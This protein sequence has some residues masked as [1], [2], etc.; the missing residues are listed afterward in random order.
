MKKTLIFL[1]VSNI[2]NGYAQKSEININN[3]DIIKGFSDKVCLCLDSVDTVNKQKTELNK[4]IGDCIDKQVVVYQLSKKLANSVKKGEEIKETNI[5]ININPD[6]KDYK[7]SYYE[8]EEYLF[9]NCERMKVLVAAS[10]FHTDKSLS[11]NALALEFYYAGI[12]E[13]E[14]ENWSTAIENYKMAVQ[15]DPEFAFAWDN[16]GI[17]Y[18]RIKDYDNSLNAYKNSLKADPKGKMPL[19]NIAVVYSY[20]GEYQNAIQAFQEFDKIYPNDPEVYYGIGQ[21]YYEHLKEYEKSLD[22]MC[23]AYNIYTETKSPYRTD[24]QNIIGYIYKIMKDK[25]QTDLFK[26]I[27]KK[28]KLNPN[29]E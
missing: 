9:Q 28:N 21:I 16:L 1:L 15:K 20:K 11:K 25:N 2:S 5:Q 26:T 4:D 23:K 29:I 27:L 17:C 24:A 22:Y 10:D 14:K 8:L 19:Q 6:S 18:R 3:D 13:S 7:D 12:K